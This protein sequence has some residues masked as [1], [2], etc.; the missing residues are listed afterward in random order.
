[1]DVTPKII[2]LYP[3]TW[4]ECDNKIFVICTTPSDRLKLT[5][6]P[7]LVNIIKTN[8]KKN[9]I[10]YLTDKD[11][12]FNEEHNTFDPTTATN[13]QIYES[14]LSPN[15]LIVNTSI[16]N[17][18]KIPNTDIKYNHLGNIESMYW[19]RNL[20][21]YLNINVTQDKISGGIIDANSQITQGFTPSAECVIRNLY[22]DIEVLAVNEEFPNPEVIQNQVTSISVVIEYATANKSIKHDNYLL[23]TLPIN[24]ELPK[25]SD[26]KLINYQTEKELIIGWFGVI[27]QFDPD[28]IIQYNGDEFD[29]P[30]I[31]KRCKLN[32]IDVTTLKLSSHGEVYIEKTITIKFGKS[33]TIERLRIPGVEIVDLLKLFRKLFISVPNY[34]L[35]TVA[36]Q[37][38]GY[39]KVDI[40]MSEM[41][42]VYRQIFLSKIYITDDIK[43]KITKFM[44]YSI[45][46][47]LLLYNLW[48]N[49]KLESMLR[50]TCNALGLPISH[51]LDAECDM[52]SNYAMYSYDP[53]TIFYIPISNVQNKLVS[54]PPI[55]NGIYKNVELYKYVDICWKIMKNSNHRHIKYLSETMSTMTTSMIECIYDSKFVDD[56]DVIS[57]V[58]DKLLELSGVHG[59]RGSMGKYLVYSNSLNPLKFD[60]VTLVGKF[61]ILIAC[62][63]SYVYVNVDNSIGIY[64]LNNYN[65]GNYKTEN[66]ISNPSF[67]LATRYRNYLIMMILNGINISNLPKLDTKLYIKQNS[68]PMVEA[69]KELTLT[70]KVRDISTYYPNQHDRGKILSEQYGKIN[71]S[72]MVNYI[73]TS[74]A[75]KY[76]VL[77]D[78]DYSRDEIDFEYYNYFMEKILVTLANLNVISV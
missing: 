70:A 68:I 21:P 20:K 29:I 44:E 54:L 46:D 1:M 66:Y 23:Y 19:T 73:K 36:K 48:N 59:V 34:K 5:I 67:Q 38:L 53:G 8:D 74:N 42:N 60:D 77:R 31:L 2:S 61:K 57:Q 75:P 43:S 12:I 7:E 32:N 55:H 63:N 37:F 22:F 39:G 27:R 47:S 65:I 41:L 56:P 10:L 49:I 58:N 76:R 11:Y 26:I 4:W 16:N 3:L 64:R 50:Q 18:L 78:F 45:T 13:S 6:L 28:R 14:I 52:L 33:T 51:F 15:V 17:K 62:D 25:E 30:Y 72:V 71:D 9:T 40:N 24:I 35:D 69:L